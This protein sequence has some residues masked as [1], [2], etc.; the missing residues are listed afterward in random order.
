MPALESKF[1]ETKVLIFHRTDVKITGCLWGCNSW[2]SAIHGLVSVLHL[3]GLSWEKHHELW[4]LTGQ[5]K[6]GLSEHSGNAVSMEH[7]R[8]SLSKSR[9]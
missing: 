3:S 8:D 6:D 2:T 5:N 1:A 9:G 4:A 7:G